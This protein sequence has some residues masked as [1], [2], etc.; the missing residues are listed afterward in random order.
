VTDTLIQDFTVTDL[1]TLRG[2]VERFAAGHG[3]AGLPL[4]RFVVAV[5]ELTTNAVRHGGGTGRLELQRLGTGLRCR[6][7]DQG[8]GMPSGWAGDRPPEPR[9]PHGRGLWLARQIAVTLEID[10]RQS[11][12]SVTLITRT[13]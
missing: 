5:N 9:N 1:R 2:E 11:G 8:P 10:S 12:T 6:V 3:L 4:Y 13:V 7:V